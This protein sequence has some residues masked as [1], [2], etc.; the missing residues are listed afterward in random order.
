MRR[1]DSSNSEESENLEE[2]ELTPEKIYCLL[3][4]KFEDSINSY[5]DVIGD[6]DEN[7]KKIK[8]ILYMISSV[9]SESLRTDN[10]VHGILS[11]YIQSTGGI[12][13]KSKKWK[14]RIKAVK[15]AFGSFSFDK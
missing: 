10:T 3:Y 14:K 9:A 12:D 5:L 2:T 8:V 11:D 1:S 6:T 15:K 4:M 13:F 7:I